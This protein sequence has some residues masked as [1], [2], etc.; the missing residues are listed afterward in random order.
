MNPKNQAL[1][2]DEL[3]IFL[4][5]SLDGIFIE[6]VNGDILICNQAGADMFGYTIEEIT[7]LNIQDLVPASECFYIKEKYTKQ[8]LFPQEYI[9]R[10]N[11]KK[12]GTLI[13]TE[14][15]SKIVTSKGKQYLIAFI[16]D[17]TKLPQMD[18]NDQKAQ[19]SQYALERTREKEKQTLL[20]LHDS[21][22]REKS[23]VPL[24]AVEY[25]ESFKKKVKIYL[26]NGTVLESY[27]T[28][29][30][31]EQQIIP[32]GSFLRCYQSYIINMQCANL[33]SHHQVFIM[34]S[35][36]RIPIRKRQYR[37][38]STTYMTYKSLMT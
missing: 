6:N 30:R 15:N 36:V 37:H 16:R 4:N 25:I 35:G 2:D 11:V 9:G 33:D 27:D 28:L 5:L 23:V 19:F 1:F 12:D 17:A 13:R 20:E 14:I 10:L 7:Q 21:V 26:K 3:L 31:L 32:T 22:G 18:P 24:L 38:I 29:N 8:D 34:D